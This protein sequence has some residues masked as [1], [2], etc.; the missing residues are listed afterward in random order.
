MGAELYIIRSFIRSDLGQR[1]RCSGTMQLMSPVG[2]RGLCRA[3][4]AGWVGAAV[5]CGLVLQQICCNQSD[6][7]AHVCSCLSHCMNCPLDSAHFSLEMPLQQWGASA[8]EPVLLW[9]H[10]R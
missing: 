7:L 9:Q 3:V 10:I 8:A 6:A 1:V 5:C 2:P 4:C